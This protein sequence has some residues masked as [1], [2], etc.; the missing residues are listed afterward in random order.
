MINDKNDMPICLIKYNL[1][2]LRLLSLLYNLKYKPLLTPF[3][4][5]LIGRAWT[6]SRP[7]FFF[8]F[9]LL[10][11][12]IILSPVLPQIIGIKIDKS[13]NILH[14]LSPLF[15]QNIIINH[16]LIRIYHMLVACLIDVC[17]VYVAEETADPP[18]VFF[19]LSLF[20]SIA[21]NLRKMKERVRSTL[22]KWGR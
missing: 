19:S 12:S 1:A 18:F 22:W 2:L 8:F 4:N 6:V 10:L 3:H 20:S 7:R 21:F 9:F 13:N 11:Y 15:I 16:P 5:E 14:Y 17:V